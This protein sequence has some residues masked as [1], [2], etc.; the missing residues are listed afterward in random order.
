[1]WDVHNNTYTCVYFVRDKDIAFREQYVEV[2]GTIHDTIM[3]RMN[4][5]INK[6][7]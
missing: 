1:M 7:H 4:E 3:A 5:N 6:T 2:Y